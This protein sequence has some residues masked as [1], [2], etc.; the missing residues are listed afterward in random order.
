MQD[1]SSTV[2]VVKGGRKVGWE[3]ERQKQQVDSDDPPAAASGWARA[4]AGQVTKHKLAALGISVC[5]IP[6]SKPLNRLDQY[7]HL[8]DYFANQSSLPSHGRLEGRGHLE[9]G[10]NRPCVGP[11]PWSRDEGQ[12]PMSENRPSPSPSFRTAI[13]NEDDEREREKYLGQ[14]QTESQVATTS[15]S[16][17]ASQGAGTKRSFEWLETSSSERRTEPAHARS[18]GVHSILNPTEGGDLEAMSRPSSPKQ[19]SSSSPLAA[20]PTASAQYTQHN[21]P[22]VS[23]HSQPRRI[24]TPISPSVRHDSVNG[25]FC[26]ASGKV[27]VTESPF[28]LAPPTRAFSTQTTTQAPI[29]ARVS[30]NVTLPSLNAPVYSSRHSTPA[31]HHSRHPSGGLATN[32]S[33]QASSPSTPHSTFSTFA[34]S[35]PSIAP[36]LLQPSGQSPIDSQQL[37]F[38]SMEPLSRTPSRMSS[39]RYGEEHAHLPGPPEMLGQNGPLIPLM[40]DLKSGSRSQAEKR[41]ANSDASRR[42]RNRKK[43]E[44]MLEQRITQLMEQ[45]QSVTEERDFYRS[46]RDYFRDSLGR[47]VGAGQMTP[48]PTSP[49]HHRRSAGNSDSIKVDGA[50]KSAGASPSIVSLQPRPPSLPGPVHRSGN[51]TSGYTAPPISQH[52]PSY[53]GSWP[54]PNAAG[55]D[56]GQAPYRPPDAG[57]AGNWNRP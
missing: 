35:S 14:L 43:N 7:R 46:E 50:S 40:I 1:E 47:H 27:S 9:R 18:I 52:R 37:S 13:K 54:P 48:R 22:S 6:H 16:R 55:S 12:L 19:Q 2:P 39:S 25:K 36:G 4:A 57:F 5:H 30:P 31:L 38:G 51:E 17:S 56:G 34:Q 20:V 8:G 24:I 26:P 45:L 44:A 15:L 3:L 32:P 33:S 53:P 10:K 28:V 49:R 42:F 21:R 41:K 29:E 11:Q 23:P